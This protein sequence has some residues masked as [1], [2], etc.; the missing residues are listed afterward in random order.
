[1]PGK[2]RLGKLA[3]I[4]GKIALGLTAFVFLIVLACVI[5]NSFDAALSDQAKAMLATPPNPYPPD[6]N[7]YLAMS[8]LEG[9]GERTIIDMGQERIEA[10]NQALDSLLPSPELPLEFN[11][12]WESSKLPFSGKL[13][14]GGQRTTSIWTDVKSH[15]QDVTTAL[16]ANQLLYERYLS[17]HSLHGYYETARPSYLAPLVFVSPQLRILFL[18]DIAIRLQTGTL[19]ERGEALDDIQQDLQM[20]KVVLQG[21]GTVLS[22]VLAVAS[23]HGDLILMADLIA[24]PST[25]PSSLSDALDSILLAFDPKDYRIGN[26]FAAEFR[27][28]A[29]LYKTITFANE[30]KLS[31]A[32]PWRQRTWNAVQAHFF[33]VNATENM[34]AAQAAQWVALGNSEPAQFYLN[35]ERYREWLKDNGPHLSPTFLYNPT[36]KILAALAGSQNDA[37]MLRVF[38]V[39]AYQRL[40]YLAFQLKRQHVMNPDVASFLKAHPEWSIHPVDGKPFS[41]NAESG[42]LAVNTLG[43]HPTG[44]RFSVFVGRSSPSGRDPS[45]PAYL[46]PELSSCCSHENATPEAPP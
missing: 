42:E 29:A 22:K 45:A 15:R 5:V 3:R 19:R 28:T 34:G 14:V 32:P 21:D 37:Y 2:S 26:A 46:R 27:V 38:D 7:L 24:D 35:R 4:T 44:Q 40:V 6:Q 31:P 9:A 33:K 20:W 11:K 13:E 23:L 8:G 25:D 16:V 36:G 43:P 41:W 18:S 17:L 30:Y 1:M 12:K 39:A 10:Y